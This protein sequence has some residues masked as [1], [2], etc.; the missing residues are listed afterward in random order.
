[1]ESNNKIDLTNKFTIDELDEVANG[2]GTQII[3]YFRQNMSPQE[4]HKKMSEFEKTLKKHDLS[5][6]D[7]YLNKGMVTGKLLSTQ[8][9]EGR[10]RLDEYIMVES[11]F[12]N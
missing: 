5:T 3:Q 7:I 12:W 1:M 6:V 4:H 2:L 10:K 8:F 9:E 11:R